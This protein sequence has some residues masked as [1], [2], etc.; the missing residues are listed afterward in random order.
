MAAH[1]THHMRTFSFVLISLHLTFK[2]VRVVVRNLVSLSKSMVER[3]AGAIVPETPEIGFGS[4]LLF[5]NNCNYFNLIVSE[6]NFNF[7]FV[8]HHKF[9]SFDRIVVIWR[10]PCSVNIACVFSC[11][12]GSFNIL[13]DIIKL[14]E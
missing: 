11:S 12:L 13:N 2:F 6:T 7:K 10:L 1:F 14:E 4:F 9:I 8:G 3:N 5:N